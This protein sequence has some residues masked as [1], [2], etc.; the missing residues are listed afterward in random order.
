MKFAGRD[1]ESSGF[2][3]AAGLDSLVFGFVDSI[4]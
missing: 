2:I 1:G 4:D 3:E